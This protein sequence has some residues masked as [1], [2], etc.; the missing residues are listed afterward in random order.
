VYCQLLKLL[1]FYSEYRIYIQIKIYAYSTNYRHDHQKGINAYLDTCTY[2]TQGPIYMRLS[3]SHRWERTHAVS[4]VLLWEHIED[5]DAALGSLSS[6]ANP[7]L[8]ILG[9]ICMDVRCWDRE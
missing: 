1:N 3:F 7:S 9:P 4:V 2:N 8:P 6:H 5:T